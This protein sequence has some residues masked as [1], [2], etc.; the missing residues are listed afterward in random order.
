MRTVTVLVGGRLEDQMQAGRRGLCHVRRQANCVTP[1]ARKRVPLVPTM[2][3]FTSQVSRCNSMCK[4]ISSIISRS[5][6]TLF[7]YITTRSISMSFGTEISR[8]IP[9]HHG[10]LL[11]IIQLTKST[12][13]SDTDQ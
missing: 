9:T 11:H 12:H 3:S 2:I 1:S 13:H 10:A 7:V 8:Y 4:F 5:L 6:A